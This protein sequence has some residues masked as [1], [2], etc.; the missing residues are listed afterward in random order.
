[1]N[2][3]ERLHRRRQFRFPWRSRRQVAEELEAELA[4]HIDASA[5]DLVAKGWS[6]AAARSE[7]VRRFGDMDYTG[8]YCRREDARREQ[9]KRR[10]TMLDE[11]WQDLT[12]AFR[13]MRSSRGF[14][15]AALLTLALGIGANTAVFSVV[16]SVL[17]DPLPFHDAG[18]LVRVFHARPS[19]GNLRGAV[20]E[21][22]FLDWRESSRTAR[23][24]ARPVQRLFAAAPMPDLEVPQ[25]Q[26]YRT[27]AVRPVAS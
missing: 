13:S 7:A 10:T 12:F 18:Q 26:T 2:D 24:L 14:T 25:T 4:F 23:L 17:L 21:P 19:S 22:D 27:A 20:S 16:H 6:D 1:M 9:E 5:A 8:A 3:S 11:L 15:T